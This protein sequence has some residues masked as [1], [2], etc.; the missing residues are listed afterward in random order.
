MVQAAKQDWRTVGLATSSHA[1][2][3]PGACQQPTEM[4]VARCSI[5][6]NMAA[7]LSL[8]I[9][10]QLAPGLCYLALV[11][12]QL[13]VWATPQSTVQWLAPT[14]LCSLTSAVEGGGCHKPRHN[15]GNS[16][17]AILRKVSC[18]L[19]YVISTRPCRTS[20]IA[21]AAKTASPAQPTHQQSKHVNTRLTSEH[22]EPAS[23]IFRDHEIHG[24]S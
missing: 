18:W 15:T 1:V 6:S 13:L 10:V 12:L 8:N 7:H 9:V 4:V 20:L 5:R 17:S 23:S 22:T 19:F 21:Q 24:N 11:C 16:H 3:I 14:P 2:R